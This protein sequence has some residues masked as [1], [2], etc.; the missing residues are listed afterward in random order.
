MG[1]LGREREE[2]RKERTEVGEGD[3]H[4]RSSHFTPWLGAGVH[5]SRQVDAHHHPGHHGAVCCGRHLLA[6]RAMAVPTDHP[7][8]CTHHAGMELEERHVSEGVYSFIIMHSHSAKGILFSA[9]L[10]VFFGVFFG[11]LG[12]KKDARSLHTCCWG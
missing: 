2:E 1:L 9:V 6:L 10:G 11:F 4:V 7:H 3:G 5:A 8:W 12:W